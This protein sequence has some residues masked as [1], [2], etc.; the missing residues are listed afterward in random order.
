MRDYKNVKVPRSYRGS[1][2]RSTVKR[3]IVGRTTGRSRAGGT[4]IK[5]VALQIITVI[6]IAAGGLLA[7]K[8]YQ[9]LLHAEMFQIA[10][11]DVKGAKQVSQADLKEIAGVF[12]GQNIFRVDLETPV[13]RAR[14]NPWVKDVR[15]YR[16]LPNRISMVITERVAFALLDTGN[17]RYVMDSEGVVIDKVAKENASE[18][19]LPVVAVKESRI[20]LGEQVT[21]EGMAEALTLVAEIA[22][23]GGWRMNEVTIK[24]GSPE[25]LSVLYADHEFKIGTGNY[26]EKLRRLAEILSDGTQRGLEIAYVDLRPER[27]AAVMVKNAGGKG[28]GSGVKKKRGT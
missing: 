23:R 8:G 26:P 16:R 4:G 6:L 28:Q 20:R 18:W 1:S 21:Y 22:E 12:T 14:A 11:V 17:S 7:W 15:I 13:R 3:A 27:Q 24:A 9:M 5:H 2:N 19:Q 10:G 25:T